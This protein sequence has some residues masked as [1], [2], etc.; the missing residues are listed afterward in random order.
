LSTARLIVDFINSIGQK[1]TL[2]R[3]KSM[4]ALPPKADISA[5]RLDVRFVPITDIARCVVENKQF[6][7]NYASVRWKSLLGFC[8]GGAFADI[9]PDCERDEAPS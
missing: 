4:S 3:V 9:A 7:H 1:Q 8:V 6:R 5:R 2:R